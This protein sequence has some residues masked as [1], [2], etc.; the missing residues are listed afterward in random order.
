VQC[1]V[2]VGRDASLLEQRPYSLHLFVAWAAANPKAAKA[3]I[4]TTSRVVCDRP[5]GEL[6][7]TEGSFEEVGQT[8]QSLEILGGRSRA[9]ADSNVRRLLP[10]PLIKGCYGVT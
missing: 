7:D 8:E 5:D 3:D 10:Y 6:L 1:L 2:S 4:S 9:Y